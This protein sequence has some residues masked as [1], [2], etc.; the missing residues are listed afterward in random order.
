VSRALFAPAEQQARLEAIRAEIASAGAEAMLVD[1]AELLA[2]AT[3]FTISETMYRAAV[4]PL[5]GAP[6]WVLRE[7]DREPCLAATWFTDVTGFRDDADP[8]AEVAAALRQRGLGTCRL[9]ADSDSHGHTLHTRRRLEA[10]LPGLRF[11]DR[12]GASD[13]LRRCKSAAEIGLLREAA[14]IG[15]AAMEAIRA[16]CRPGLTEAE[17]AAIAAAEFLRHGADSGETG[18]ILRAA[19]DAGFLHGPRGTGPL[20]RGDV[21]HVEL[22]PRRAL[23]SARV[24]RP[25]LLGEDRHGI[26]ALVQRLATLQDRQIA[27]MRPGVPARD[28]DALLRD[29]VLAAGLRQDYANVTGYSL[30]LYG[31]T[32]RVSDFSFALHPGADWVLEAG[33]AFH[34]YVSAGGAAISETVIV[35]ET[36][37]ERL[38]GLPRTA[39]MAV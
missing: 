13:R 10:L 22:V 36:G 27:A 21:L 34:M 4:V 28:A 23:Y 9:L 32:P 19:G 20:A 7:L 35:R 11:V 17:A 31:R 3:G 2:W 1:Q 15:D 14:A 24:M 39:L 12:P 29:A 38:S 30:G 33:M 26:A 5:D 25:I 37:G 8:H 6:F 18:P 16:A